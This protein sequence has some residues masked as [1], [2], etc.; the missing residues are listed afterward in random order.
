MFHKPRIRKQKSEIVF[1]FLFL[2]FSWSS[3]TP[4]TRHMVLGQCSA[5]GPDSM[6]QRCQHVVLQETP[7]KCHHGC[8]PEVAHS[9][10]VGE[11][12]M[13]PCIAVFS[14]LLFFSLS[15]KVFFGQFNHNASH[16]LLWFLLPYTPSI[17]K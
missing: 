1:L 3:P 16:M 2:D 14:S 6:R 5:L 7:R 11:D 8:V 12:H 13:H 10:E 17:L 4:D 9:Q 15:P